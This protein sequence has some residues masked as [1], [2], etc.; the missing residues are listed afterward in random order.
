MTRLNPWRE[1]ARR[2]IEEFAQATRDSDRIQFVEH[3]ADTS[4]DLAVWQE[5]LE[6][7]VLGAIR[8]GLDK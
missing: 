6:Y 3:L 7:A 2:I 1:Q 4:T 5:I 8:K